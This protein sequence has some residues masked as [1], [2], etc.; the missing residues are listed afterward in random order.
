[1]RRFS[2]WE[3]F[4]V[5]GLFSRRLY[6]R[7]VYVDDPEIVIHVVVHVECGTT[8]PE[9]ERLDRET[10]RMLALKR[11]L[12][13]E[14]VLL[15]RYLD[16]ARKQTELNERLRLSQG[17]QPKQL[18]YSPQIRSDKVRCEESDR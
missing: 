4:E 10:Q 6:R 8:D 13:A 16:V 17:Q 11:N 9:V 15:D 14:L 2:H 1:M 12:D 7:P 5:R 18:S 3:Y